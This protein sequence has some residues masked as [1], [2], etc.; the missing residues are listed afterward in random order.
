MD[1]AFAMVQSLDMSVLEVLRGSSNDISLTLPS[2]VPDWSDTSR[3]GDGLTLES[4]SRRNP[5]LSP[6]CQAE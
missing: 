6:E 5:V 3:F 4:H 1:S 2:W